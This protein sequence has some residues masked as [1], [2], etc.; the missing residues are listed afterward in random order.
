[1]KWTISEFSSEIMFLLIINKN[2]SS[3]LYS[4]VLKKNPIGNKDILKH[5]DI[6]RHAFTKVLFLKINS[7]ENNEKGSSLQEVKEIQFS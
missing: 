3:Y 5:A 4:I 1:M 7:F 2:L 6:I